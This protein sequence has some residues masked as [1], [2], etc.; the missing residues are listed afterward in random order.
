MAPQPTLIE[1]VQTPPAASKAPEPMTVA[2][3]P[4][5]TVVRP[6]TARGAAPVRVASTASNRPIGSKVEASTTVTPS[7]ATEP[8]PRN[9]LLT[10]RQPD[11]LVIDPGE[12]SVDFTERF[13]RDTKPIKPND[14]PTLQLQEDL[15]VADGFL[16]NPRWVENATP[17]QVTAM[18][19]EA[20]TKRA[21]LYNR[22]L[23][24]DGTGRKSEH[25]TFAIKVAAD[26]SAKIKDKA[27][28]QRQGLFSG[29]FDVTDALMRN[30]GIDPYSSYKL[31]VLDETRDERVAMGKVHRTQQLA[32]AKQLVHKNLEYLWATMSDLSARKQGLFDLWDDCAESGPEDVVVAGRSARE[33]VIGFIRS[34]LPASGATAITADELVRFNRERKSKATFAPYL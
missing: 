16:K 11:R 34:K 10:M 30:Q 12:L 22:E 21:E 6:A 8:A 13:L 3:L 5:H 1:I 33:Y 14:N 15:R 18:R 17:D 24:P 32:Q 9:P 20:M 28:L 7:T 19:M 26:G 25:K 23:Q 2:L 31:K 27:N 29:T 4:D